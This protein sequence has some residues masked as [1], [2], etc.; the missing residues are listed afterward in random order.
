[1]HYTTGSTTMW[2]LH[3]TFITSA[4][5]RPI[6]RK[7]IKSTYTYHLPLGI[8]SSICTILPTTSFLQHP[9]YP[10]LR[11]SALRILQTEW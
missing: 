7:K 3:M 11:F 5:A 10:W 8:L 1:M 6:I 9:Q 4:S 2:L